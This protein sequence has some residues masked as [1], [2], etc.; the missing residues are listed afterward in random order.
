MYIDRNEIEEYPFSGRFITTIIDTSKPL[1][2][3][4]EEE[5]VVLE[6]DCDIQE[7]TKSLSGGITATYAVYFPFDKKSGIGGIKNGM[8]FEGDLYGL[9]VNGEVKGIFPTQMGGC[10]AYI[11]D[12]DV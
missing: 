3:Q 2:E 5:V 12:K 10:V 8:R 7:S 1:D 11:V 9:R 4:V 6:T